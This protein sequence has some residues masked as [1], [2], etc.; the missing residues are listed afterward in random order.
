MK[1]PR[2]KW[3]GMRIAGFECRVRF[4]VFRWRINLPNFRYGTCLSVG[5]LHVWFSA[6][7]AD[8]DRP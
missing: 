8:R 2:G 5:P 3:N 4:D 6:S 1:W 7:Y